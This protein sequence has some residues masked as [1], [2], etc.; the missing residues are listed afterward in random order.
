MDKIGYLELNFKVK[1]PGILVS[2]RLD[3]SIKLW[4][5]ETLTCTNTLHK[6]TVNFL[7]LTSGSG[8]S[9]IMI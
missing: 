7:T 3:K 4:N 6:H 1:L 5:G 2:G 9:T 8:D